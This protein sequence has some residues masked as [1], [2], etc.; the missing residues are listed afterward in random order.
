MSRN[1]HLMHASA[2]AAV[3]LALSSSAVGTAV[4]ADAIGGSGSRVNGVVSDTQSYAAESVSG[5][6]IWW[7]GTTAESVTA[8]PDIWWP[9]GTTDDVSASPVIWWPGLVV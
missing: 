1:R 8:S 4:A 9:D 3:V 5:P 7:P 6:D 2:V